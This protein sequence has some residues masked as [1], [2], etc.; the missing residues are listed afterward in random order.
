[1]FALN[2]TLLFKLLYHEI[3]IKQDSE[4]ML[5]MTLWHLFI[6]KVLLNKPEA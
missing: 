2:D 6:L 4:E 1:M 5:E 3:K